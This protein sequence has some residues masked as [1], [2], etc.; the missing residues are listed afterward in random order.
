VAV[1]ENVETVSEKAP[2]CPADNVM[3]EALREIAGPDGEIEA[4][5]F[6]VP[7]NPF[8][9][10]KVT[11]EAADEPTVMVRLLGLADTVKSDG[12]GTIT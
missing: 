5:R 3:L 8:T 12:A 10:L 4:A 11:V 7:A 1:E 6:M 9:L 2:L